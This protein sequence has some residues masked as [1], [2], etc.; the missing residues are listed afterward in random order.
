MLI[1]TSEEDLQKLVDIINAESEKMG[2][3][4]NAKKTEVM[5]ISKRPEPPTCSIKVLDATLKQAQSFK[6]LGSII[7]PDGRCTTDIKSRLGQ[8]RTAFKNLEAILT[9]QKISI[10]VRKRVLETYIWPII[11]YGCEA[12][13]INQQ[14]QNTINAAEMWYYRKMFKIPYIA[15]VT[16]EEVLKRAKTTRRL[17]NSIRKRQAS[18]LG[19]CLRKGGLEQQVT[20][21]KIPGKRDRGRQREKMPDSL[22]GWLGGKTVTKTLQSASDR[23]VWKLMVANAYRQGT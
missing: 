1:A 19:H 17:L 13:T 7:T 4:L 2:L 9:N 12:W 8:A 22:S 20:T 11:T 18:F 5:T 6:Y 21:G 3:G 23:S 10:N 16:N 14:M 15:H